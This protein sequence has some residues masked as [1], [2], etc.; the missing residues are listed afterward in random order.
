MRR[1]KHR[2]A[3]GAALI[4]QLT[5]DQRRLGPHRKL[6][7][8]VQHAAAQAQWTGA[9]AVRDGRIVYVGPDA[10]ASPLI[11]TNTRVIDLAGKMLLPG[12]HDSHV[13]LVGGGIELGESGAQVITV[14]DGAAVLILTFAEPTD[15]LAEMGIA[16]ATRGR[17]TT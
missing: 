17:V 8:A 7:H 14:R 2:E 11:G 12:F 3:V 9:V 15:A 16:D 5:G 10:G 13:H 6:E 1:A 4:E